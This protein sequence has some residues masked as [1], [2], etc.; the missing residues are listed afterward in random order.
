MKIKIII[1]AAVMAV[2]CMF[3]VGGAF[4]EENKFELNESYGIKDVLNSY[5]GKRVSLRTDTGEALEGT[6]TKVGSHLVHISKL[7]GKDFYDAVVVIDKINSVV[8]RVRGN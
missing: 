4:A 2:M 1:L 6:V 5:M 3:F 8:I 7:S